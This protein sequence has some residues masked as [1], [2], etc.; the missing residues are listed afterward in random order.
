MIEIYDFNEEQ[1]DQH[2]SWCPCCERNI[3]VLDD[4][5]WY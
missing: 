3:R 2:P 4:Y 1:N 5:G